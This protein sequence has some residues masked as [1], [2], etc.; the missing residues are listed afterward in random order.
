MIVYLDKFNI[1]DDKKSSKF[2]NAKVK[3][4]DNE[5]EIKPS[6]IGVSD[7]IQLIRYFTE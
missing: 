7:R 6:E 5:N 2:S 3:N 4:V 1:D